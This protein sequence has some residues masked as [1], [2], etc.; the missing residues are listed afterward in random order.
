MTCTVAHID[1]FTDTPYTGNPAVVCLLETEVSNATMQSIATEMNVSDTAFVH[2]HERGP[3]G[4]KL[5]WFTPTM[6]VPLCGHATLASAHFLWEE[7]VVPSGDEIVFSTDSGRLSARRNAAQIELDFPIEPVVPEATPENLQAVL[8]TSAWRTVTRC[9]LGYLVELESEEIVRQLAPN[10]ELLKA[11]PA[12]AMIVTSRSSSPEY[13]FV[14]R[15]FAPNAGIPEDPVTGS[16]HCS[17]A[18]YWRDV[19]GKDTMVGFQAS[20]RGGRVRVTVLGD[21]V[22]IAGSA[23]TVVRGELLRA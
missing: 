21:R 16:S 8:G 10:Q 17:L 13:D 19:L 23:V 1:A 7:Q 6:E 11:L 4:F 22:V 18:P 9:H 2:L 12:T 20:E 5:R 3:E 14:S 15:V